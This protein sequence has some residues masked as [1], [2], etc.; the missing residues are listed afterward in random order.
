MTEGTNR[1]TSQLYQ[2]LFKRLW[3]FT[4]H[5]SEGWAEVYGEK[6]SLNAILSD[7]ALPLMALCA[8]TTFVGFIFN[9][10]GFSLELALK[11]ATVIFIAL[12]GGLYLAYFI[13]SYVLSSEM[14]KNNVFA[15]SAYSSGL[16]YVVTLITSLVPE[17]LMANLLVFYAAYI[18]WLGMQQYLN[19]AEM[20]RRVWL[21][22][23]LFVLIHLLPSLI[24]YSLLK[25]VV[26][27]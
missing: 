22:V 12:F 25:L 26:Y 27:V 21:T 15:L 11:Q 9:H 2:D 23:L 4:I 6:K 18:I 10:Q 19:K 16:G 24:Y 20:N 13:M 8:L 7:F 1:T 5:P 17:F 3:L 14:E